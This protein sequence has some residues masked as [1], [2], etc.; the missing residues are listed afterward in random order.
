MASAYG[1]RSTS[2]A[3]LLAK[4]GGDI[5]GGLVLVPEGE[6]APAGPALLNPALERDVA[7][8]INAIKID[9]DSWAPQDVPARFSLAG[10]QGKFALARVGDDWYWSNATVPSTHIIK[11]GRPELRGLEAAEAA[12]LTLAARA[13]V[14]APAAS[15]LHAE[16]QSAFMVERFDREP[17]PGPLARRL[18]AEDLAQALGIRSESKYH[19]SARQVVA[20]LTTVDADGSL[21]RGFLVQLAFNTIVG[22]A[23][24]HAKNCS[25]LLRP[26]G[27]RLAPLYDVVPVG[28]YP[29]FSQELAM[30]IAGARHPRAASPDHW[31]KLARTIGLDE[32]EAVTIA[33]GTAA[34]VA[35]LNDTAWDNLDDDQAADLRQIVGRHA[36][37]VAR[38]RPS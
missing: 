23:D 28:L 3:D 33:R 18:H 26:D 12:A 10:T 34:R 37:A 6:P 1:A 9:P 17:G 4:A 21:V 7:G 24:A 36:E 19:V 25:V 35:E 31:R 30:P 32:D 27:V 22:N 38:L 20:L 13:G 2:T 15:V 14:P 29:Q 16:D 8:R 11:P 5:A